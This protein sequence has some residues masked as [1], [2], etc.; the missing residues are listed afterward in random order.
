M[1]FNL[2]QIES[3]EEYFTLKVVLKLNLLADSHGFVSKLTSERILSEK[4][5]C[6]KEQR[7]K[8]M[9]LSFTK[10]HPETSGQWMNKNA[11]HIKL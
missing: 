10:Q 2:T 9:W 1:S 8:L 6:Q 11:G 4:Q 5:L 3:I 7:T